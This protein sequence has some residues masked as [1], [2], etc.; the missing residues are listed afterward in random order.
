[1]VGD[2]FCIPAEMPEENVLEFV[3]KI[4][5]VAA[6]EQRRQG[7]VARIY[8]LWASNLALGDS[9]T[10]YRLSPGTKRQEM[11]GAATR[12]RPESSF[13]T[14]AATVSPYETGSFSIRANGTPAMGSFP[15]LE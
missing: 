2:V 15:R 5:V 7:N 3:S 8:L 13:S 10:F 1:M 14:Y 6:V 9:A 12:R 11:R 4:E